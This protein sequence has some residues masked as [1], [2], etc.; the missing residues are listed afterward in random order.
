MQF[1]DVNNSLIQKQSFYH[2]V[3]PSKLRNF[4]V[5]SSVNDVGVENMLDIS[6]EL[7]SSPMVNAFNDGTMYSRIYI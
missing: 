5:N 3:L 4:Y 7:L 2:Q 1:Y 6:F